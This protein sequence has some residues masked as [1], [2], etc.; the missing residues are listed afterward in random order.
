MVRADPSRNRPQ[1]MS[2]STATGDQLT[3]RGKRSRNEEERGANFLQREVSYGSFERTVK[4][5]D[6]VKPE[7]ITASYRNGVLELTAPVGR[8]HQ[9]PEGSDSGREQIP[10]LLAC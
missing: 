9:D 7:E 8:G 1:G 3:I 10:E 4:L 5:P 6:G 2:R